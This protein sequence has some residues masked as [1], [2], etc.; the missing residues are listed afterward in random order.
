MN[1]GIFHFVG[2]RM[3]GRAE[4][5]WDKEEKLLVSILYVHNHI[6]YTFIIIACIIL[7]L[8]CTVEGRKKSVLFSGNAAFLTCHPHISHILLCSWQNSAC[9]ASLFVWLSGWVC[10]WVL[11]IYVCMCAN[12]CACC[13]SSAA[14]ACHSNL[15]SQWVEASFWYLNRQ[16]CL[17][18][19][20]PPA[21]PT[22]LT[23]YLKTP[24]L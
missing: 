19:C 5:K 14:L 10:F 9:S 22:S 15:L 18:L 21:V 2:V 7:R 23:Q 4:K 8:N 16:G 1:D 13:S 20:S 12:F 17:W 11:C 3:Q 6:F 24:L